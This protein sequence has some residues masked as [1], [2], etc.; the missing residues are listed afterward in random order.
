[1]RVDVVEGG[2]YFCLVA[3]CAGASGFPGRRDTKSAPIVAVIL[4]APTS[5]IGRRSR[6]R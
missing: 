4:G 3:S 5:T 6:A 2:S 1:M